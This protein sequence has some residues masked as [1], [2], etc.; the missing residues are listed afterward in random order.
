[1]LDSPLSDQRKTF[2]SHFFLRL[3]PFV[4][5]HIETHHG[6][7]VKEPWYSEYKIDLYTMVS[8]NWKIRIS[9]QKTQTDK[10]FTFD[11]FLM[12]F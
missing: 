3:N 11:Y 5:F 9:Y 1:L 2:L 10:K 6:K 7:R 4:T 12:K 8:S